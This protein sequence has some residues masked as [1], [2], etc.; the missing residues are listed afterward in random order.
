M[1]FFLFIYKNQ[2]KNL[3]AY[4]KKTKKFALKYKQ[5]LSKA[6]LFGWCNFS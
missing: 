6:T 3:D 1:K 5:K 2:Q 4:R